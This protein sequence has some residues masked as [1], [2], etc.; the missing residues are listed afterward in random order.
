MAP[1]K[2]S[3]ARQLRKTQTEAEKLL[4]AALRNRQ[5]GGYKFRRQVPKDKFIVDFLCESQKLIVEI[6]GPTHEGRKA[7]DTE[8]T[9][10]LE[11]MGYHVMRLS[12]EDCFDDMEAVIEAIFKTLENAKP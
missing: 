10:I 1:Q 3:F 9:H 5:C 12:N 11:T 4:W 6:D 7:Y 2:T 8:R